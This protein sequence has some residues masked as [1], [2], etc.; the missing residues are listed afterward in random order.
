[1][2]FSNTPWHE[3][4]DTQNG[5]GQNSHK[6]VD[7][8]YDAWLN[9]N[10]LRDALGPSHLFDEDG[11]PVQHLESLVQQQEPDDLGLSALPSNIGSV[12]PAVGSGASTGDGRSVN[13]PPIFEAVPHPHINPYAALSPEQL[14]AFNEPGNREYLLRH[15]LPPP[16]QWQYAQSIQQQIQSSTWSSPTPQ[17][18][19]RSGIGASQH[20]SV[21]QSQTSMHYHPRPLAPYQEHASEKMPGSVLSSED[22]HGFQHPFQPIAPTQDHRLW[23]A[24]G[25][26]LD[27]ADPPN[28]VREPRVERARRQKTPRKSAPRLP[29]RKSEPC[30]W[31]EGCDKRF[32]P[33]DGREVQLCPRHF[34]KHV[35]DQKKRIPPSF[36]RATTMSWEDFCL[37][38][39]YPR[40]PP[41]RIANDNY[42][43]MKSSH[44]D[45]IAWMIGAINMP[46]TGQSSDLG[47]KVNEGRFAAQEELNLKELNQPE[48][49]NN[50]WVNIR[51]RALFVSAIRCTY[52]LAV[53]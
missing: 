48:R 23:Q 1:M 49:Y 35:I 15:G 17:T 9:P 28:Q 29:R 3:E 8:D 27:V 45:Y 38:K 20:A 11:N 30:K 21:S 26:T 52:R 51:A 46:Y 41:L 31:H 40:L 16:D 39:L 34:K 53:G 43:V 25:N 32:H 37:K 18:F 42:D 13:S 2:D 4:D 12:A 14:Q 44:P 47:D 33:V 36:E 22:V 24:S 5:E 10:A 6:D 7:V 19:D 50:E